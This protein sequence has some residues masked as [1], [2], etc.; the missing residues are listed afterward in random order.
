MTLY[1][2]DELTIITLREREDPLSRFSINMSLA[3]WQTTQ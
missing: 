1:K 2:K 3:I